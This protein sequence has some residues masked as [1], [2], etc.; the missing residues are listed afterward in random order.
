MINDVIPRSF[1]QYISEEPNKYPMTIVWDDLD[2][3]MDTANSI[4]NIFI[5]PLEGDALKVPLNIE[6][7]ETLYNEWLNTEA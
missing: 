3:D 2:F 1:L 6:E 5:H 4:N 7:I